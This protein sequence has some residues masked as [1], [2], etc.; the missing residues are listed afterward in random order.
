MI[1]LQFD[2][3]AELAEALV[4]TLAIY[5]VTNNKLIET[6]KHMAETLCSK[7]RGDDVFLPSAL[8]S[9]EVKPSPEDVEEEEE[10]YTRR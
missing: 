6:C 2:S 8:D 7:Y 4:D 5:F 3:E 9:P 10:D 1:T